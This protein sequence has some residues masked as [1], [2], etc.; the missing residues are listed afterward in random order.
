M[1][2]ENIIKNQI[3]KS[4][5]VKEAILTDVALLKNIQAAADMVTDAYRSGFKT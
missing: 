4:I 3:E 5:S 2:T 1:D